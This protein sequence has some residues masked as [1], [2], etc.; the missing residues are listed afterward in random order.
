MA[1]GSVTVVALEGVD[2]WLAAT[3]VSAAG[4]LVGFLAARRRAAVTDTRFE[5]AVGKALTQMHE[6]TVAAERRQGSTDQ[7]LSQLS[8]VLDTQMQQMRAVVAGMQSA[9]A[10]Q[11]GQ[12]VE[13][14]REAAARGADLAETTESLK[15]VLS[16]PTSRGR[17]GERAA[18]DLLRFVGM[19]EGVNYL[20][21]ATLPTGRRPDFTFLLPPD[22]D[23]LHMDVKFPLNSYEAWMAATDDPARRA[24]VSAF[25]KAL[26]GHVSDL[27]ARDGYTSSANSVGCVLMFIPN[28]AVYAFLHQQCP[29]VVDEAFDKQVLVCSP[30]TLL[31]VLTVIRRCADMFALQRSAGEILDTLREFEQQWQRC[32]KVIDT[33]DAQLDTVRSS[34]D[35]I[36]LGGVRRRALERSLG[37]V[38]ALR[39][40]ASTADAAISAEVSANNDQP[41][42]SR[43]A[44]QMPTATAEASGASQRP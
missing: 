39:S 15:R 41:S 4:C 8:S 3:V 7:G 33:V 16:N 40:G 44:G 37:R 27:A 36:S 17:W 25:K 28:D 2:I 30:S 6:Q 9:A 20:K 42:D 13:Q 10:G 11:H 31:G 32:A 38:D 21:Q 19:V 43:H 14:L 12:I 26:R 24:A 34:V 35:S 5:A 22:G 23:G 1:V 18:E 29:E